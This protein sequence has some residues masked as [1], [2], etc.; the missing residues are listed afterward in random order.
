MAVITKDLGAVSAYAV[1][2]ANG[3][4]GTEAEWEQ[5]MA[6]AANNAMNAAGSATAAANSA[7]SAAQ[8][9]TDAATSKVAAAGSAVDAENS[10]LVAGN[11]AAAAAASATA[12]ETAE[13]GAE[14]AKTAAEAAQAAAEAVAASIPEDYT[15][16]S[17]DVSSLKSALYVNVPTT[18][19]IWEQG[20]I[21][22]ATGGNSSSDNVI[23]TTG[24][25]PID[26]VDVH[27][28]TGYEVNVY[29]WSGDTYLGYYNGTTYKKTGSA[30]DYYSAKK[31]AADLISAGADNVRLAMRKT[32]G[33]V[34]VTPSEGVNVVRM[35]SRVSNSENVEAD[36]QAVLNLSASPYQHGIFDIKRC[37]FSGW[38]SGLQESYS[39]FGESTKYADVIE[40]FDALVTAYPD[41]VS[42]NALGTASGTDA[43]SNTYT[44]YE[45]VFTPKR[46]SSPYY[47]RKMPKVYMDGAIHGFE[48]NSTYGIYYFIK[49]V[50]ESWDKNP[51]LEAMRSQVEIHVIPV[52]NPYG[53]DNNIY[54]NGN[55]VNI[56]R[57]FDHPGEWTVVTEPSTEVNGAEAFDQPESAIIRDWLLAAENDILVYLNCHTNG[58]VTTGY[59]E[60]NVCMTS[61]DRNDAY[62]NK[63]IGVF[64]NHIEQQTLRF[65]AMYQDIEPSSSEMCGT[66][67]TTATATSTKG[68]ASSWADTMRKI[69]AMTLESFNALKAS[70]S[71]TI[72]SKYSD[73]SKK[74]NSE[75][76]GNM[77]LQIIAEYAPY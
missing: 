28:L 22:V 14:T 72:I 56:N 77:V 57:N 24:R 33:G 18:T 65:P 41:Y 48:K 31:I 13:T 73:D 4:T 50:C 2:V 69:M 19:D 8:S 52:S 44:V 21:A 67:T 49:D 3:F 62:F 54:V 42:K 1:A 76:I 70:E 16:L 29:G 27:T 37:D 45:Y 20:T 51:V 9:A 17:E 26:F 60:M 64:T 43:S 53:F 46:K 34:A 38:Y 68:T 71:V 47:M 63:L 66:I 74:I 32:G 40:A 23:R 75:I 12:A 55:G 7:A 15:E 61:N 39:D 36:L 11:H 59:P 25:I 10:A 58:N 35:Y 30:L 6:D 5:Y